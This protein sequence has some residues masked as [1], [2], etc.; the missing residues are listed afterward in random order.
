MIYFYSDRQLTQVEQQRATEQASKRSKAQKLAYKLMPES[1]RASVERDQPLP[2]YKN[3]AYYPDFLW[4]EAKVIIEIDGASHRNHDRKNEDFMKDQTCRRYGFKVIRIWNE[5]VAFNVGFWQKL[6]EE[7]I[8][9]ETTGNREIIAGF[10]E[11]LN[12][13]I[14]EELRRATDINY[15][16]DSIEDIPIY[17]KNTGWLEFSTLIDSVKKLHMQLCEVGR[18]TTSYP[19]VEKRGGATCINL[20]KIVNL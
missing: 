12:L 11:D 4:R 20:E 19:N 15:G 2:F 14:D 1:M 7:F 8:K 18:E 6:V 13:L 5:D 9:M 10:I 17:P 16:C 3:T